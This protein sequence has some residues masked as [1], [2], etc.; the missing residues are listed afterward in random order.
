MKKMRAVK[1]IECN[2]CE[3]MIGGFLNDN[4]SVYDMDLLLHHIDGC[5][6]CM[7]E[8]TIQY[9]VTEGFLNVEKSG[10][11]NLVEALDRKLNFSKRK[12]EKYFIKMNTLMLFFGILLLLSIMV[13]AII[14]FM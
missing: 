1:A 8:L 2:V 6:S 4:L 12:V 3:K 5:A 7:D 10:D 9:L 13:I 14:L 11:Y